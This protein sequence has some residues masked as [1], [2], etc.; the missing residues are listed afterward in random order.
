MPKKAADPEDALIIEEMK[1]DPEI[2]QPKL[3]ASSFML[4]G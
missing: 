3:T 2:N 1:R 4:L